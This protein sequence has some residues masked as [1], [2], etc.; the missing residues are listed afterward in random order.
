LT[1][2]NPPC[3]LTI[4]GALIGLCVG[5]A[6]WLALRR[7][8]RS[9]GWWIL[10]GVIGYSAGKAISDGFALTVPGPAGY[11]L[12]G[13]AIGFLVGTPLW[14]LTRRQVAVAGWCV[15]ASVLAWVVGWLII[16]VAERV[17]GGP[18]AAPYVIGGVGAA[19]A[20]VITGSYLLWARPHR[21]A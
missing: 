3:N 17:E 11:A 15:P 16:S 21:L 9:A 13:A 10:A 1:L 2:S 18:T 19:V 7:H 8:L 6:Q 4:D 14:F 20:G 5:I 12:G